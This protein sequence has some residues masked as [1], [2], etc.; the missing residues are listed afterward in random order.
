MKLRLF[1]RLRVLVSII[2]YIEKNPVVAGLAKKPEEFC[3][4]SAFLR[5]QLKLNI[6]DPIPK[7]VG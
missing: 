5:K 4:S 7:A 1:S 3:W 6:G 2:N